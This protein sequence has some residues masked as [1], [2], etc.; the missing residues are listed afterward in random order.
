MK[1]KKIIFWVLLIV[2]LIFL[3]IFLWRT[4]G[5]TEPFW[6][7]PEPEDIRIDEFTQTIIGEE[8][9]V[10]QKETKFKIKIPK[11]WIS[12]EDEDLLFVSPDFNPQKEMVLY[13]M[14]ILEEGCS[15]SIAIQ[16]EI[17]FPK[18]KY[19]EFEYLEWLIN[20]CLENKE[21]C[22]EDGDEVIEINGNKGLKY[23][24]W[25][26]DP[27]DSNYSFWIRFSKNESVYH[28]SSYF[29]SKDKERCVRE[30]EK[31]LN[32]LEIN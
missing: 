27:L 3:G 1:I 11:D 10:E 20:R 22:K 7:E 17:G 32:T 19:T 29:Y 24:N 18:N 6:P 23:T 13:G 16:K 14:P 12:I 25:E 21:E 26:E 4:Q 28:I 15:I 5:L 8:N 9:I 30:F 2:F 31:I